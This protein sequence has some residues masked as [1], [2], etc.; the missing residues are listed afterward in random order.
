MA[1][2]GGRFAN[3]I[4]W[5]VSVL[6]IIP[7]ITIGIAFHEFAHAYAAYKLGDHTP[8]FQG[9][10]TLNPVKHFDP[11]G[12][13]CIIFIG[14]GWG[15]PVMVNPMNF[16]NRRRDEII[17]SL[18]GVVTNFVLAVIFSAILG[19]MV[20]I[21]SHLFLWSTMGAILLNIVRINIV[22]MV[23]NLI[24]VPPLDGFNVLAEILR[25]KYTDTYY[26]LYN[27]G[28]WILLILIVFNVVN[29]IFRYTVTPLLSFLLSIFI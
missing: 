11:F 23:F 1:V 16:R 27:N 26:M 12:L 14:F 5:A 13:L 17:V 29:V 2:S 18:A 15:K 21:N 28:M 10:V 8:M 9:R 4:D 24:P 19:L 3:P 7:A 20:N 25:I 22:L 6:L